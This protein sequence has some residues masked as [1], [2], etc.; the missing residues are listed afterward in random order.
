MDVNDLTPAEAEAYKALTQQIHDYGKGSVATNAKNARFKEVLYDPEVSF[1]YKKTIA[2]KHFRFRV[3]TQWG[4]RNLSGTPLRLLSQVEPLK[5]NTVPYAVK[6]TNFTSEIVSII[7]AANYGAK[8][9]MRNRFINELTD[10]VVTKEFITEVAQ[11]VKNSTRNMDGL[12]ERARIVYGLGEEFP[13]EWIK[14]SLGV[15]P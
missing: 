6:N 11:K 14:R 8:L 10:E 12:Y 3:V 13:V 9:D 5:S 1:A 2:T 7:L 15:I 4:Y